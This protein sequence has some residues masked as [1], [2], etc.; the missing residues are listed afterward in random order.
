M[1]KGKQFLIG[2]GK[3]FLIGKENPI[4]IEEGKLKHTCI[5]KNNNF[6]IFLLH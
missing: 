5:I 4:L 2:K 3:Q 1:G 6:L